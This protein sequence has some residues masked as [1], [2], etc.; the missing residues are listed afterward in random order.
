MIAKRDVNGEIERDEFV[1]LGL[2]RGFV[3]GGDGR[4]EELDVRH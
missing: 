1:E 2:D 4:A 3:R